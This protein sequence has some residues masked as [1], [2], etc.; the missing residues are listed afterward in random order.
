MQL[1]KHQEKRQ[2][3]LHG[4]DVEPACMIDAIWLRII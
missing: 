2:A 3:H 4:L 1:F